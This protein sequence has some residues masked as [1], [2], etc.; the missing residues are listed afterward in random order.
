MEEE[1]KVLVF[2]IERQK[3]EMRKKQ[4]V[5]KNLFKWFCL[6]LLNFDPEISF[7]LIGVGVIFNN[8]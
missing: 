7:Y 5:L 3:E 6:K 8:F 2:E 1:M 4:E